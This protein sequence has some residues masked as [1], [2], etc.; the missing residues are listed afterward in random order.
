MGQRWCGRRLTCCSASGVPSRPAGRPS[1]GPAASALIQG[2]GLTWSAEHVIPEVGG[3]RGDQGPTVPRERG[4]I[5]IATTARWLALGAGWTSVRVPR[6]QGA[7][8]VRLWTS[9]VKSQYVAWSLERA[10]DDQF[11]LPTKTPGS[12]WSCLARPP[13]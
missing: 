6:R 3:D 8:E 9:V 4:G 13:S 11:Q 12:P 1:G 2:G 5:L 7:A 10:N